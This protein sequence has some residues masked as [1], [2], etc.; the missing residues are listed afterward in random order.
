MGSQ[1]HILSCASHRWQLPISLVDSL[2]SG[3]RFQM[4]L[5]TLLEPNG[6]YVTEP[7]TGNPYRLRVLGCDT[8]GFGSLAILLEDLERTFDN[9]EEKL[10]T[11]TL[12]VCLSQSPCRDSVSQLSAWLMAGRIGCVEISFV[13][14]GPGNHE[15]C[16]LY[17]SDA[18]DE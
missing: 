5:V 1:S 11:A 6:R 13:K 2:F 7:E 16:L 3:P 12:K 9:S 8:Q 10:A 17:T 18:A 14:G 4:A 15:S